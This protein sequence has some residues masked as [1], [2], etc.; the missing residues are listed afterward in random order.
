MSRDDTTGRVGTKLA[1]FTPSG[2]GVLAH[3][4][5]LLQLT[6]QDVLFDLGCGDARML[7]HAAQATNA[8]SVKSWYWT[9]AWMEC[10]D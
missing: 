10:E 7:V 6:A 8:K 9:V 1:P 5:D 2:D 3:A 4:L